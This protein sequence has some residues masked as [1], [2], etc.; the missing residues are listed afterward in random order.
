MV[1]LWVAVMV[2]EWV[3]LTA[4][5]MVVVWVGSLVVMTAEMLAALLD[6]P[7][8]GLSAWW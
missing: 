6:A 3:Y 2:V 4:G 1:V 5:G 8:A 7:K